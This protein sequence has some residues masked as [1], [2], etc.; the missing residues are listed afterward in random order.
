VTGS[1]EKPLIILKEVGVRSLY[2][3]K[4]ALFND[5]FVLKG[6]TE[7]HILDAATLLK[8]AGIETVF[9]SGDIDGNTPVESYPF[10]E[11]FKTK[12]WRRK[13]VQASLVRLE[14]FLREQQVDLVHLVHMH[15]PDVTTWLAQRWPTVRTIHTAYMFCLSGA[16]YLPHT[17]R[18][19]PKVCNIGCMATHLVEGCIRYERDKPF[20]LHHQIKKLWEV[21]AN[22]LADTGLHRI[23]VASQFMKD[24]LCMHDYDP[25]KVDIMPPPLAPDMES[26]QPAP[27]PMEEA[28]TIVFAGRLIAEKGTFDVIRALLMMTTPARLIIIGDG[29]ERSRLEQDAQVLGVADRVIFRGWLPLEETRRVYREGWITVFPSHWPEPFGFTGVESFLNQRPVVAYDVGGVGE[30]MRHEQN[31]LMVE[32]GN[33]QALAQAMDSLF[34]APK[35]CQEMGIWAD[36]DARERFSGQHHLKLKIRFYE[37]AIEAFKGKQVQPVVGASV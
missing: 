6:G 23:G 5:T 31:G 29:P 12:L 3:M 9:I 33:I 8:S 2:M 1:T 19:C 26:V 22:H 27:F 16:R 32:P 34:Q 37:K 14:T 28:P 13:K 35:R 30:W 10:P 18:V 17:N 11:F 15:H 20:P 24:V 25:E 21:Q 36:R 4:V 7:R